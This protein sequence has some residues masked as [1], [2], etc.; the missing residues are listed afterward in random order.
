MGILKQK[1]K[2]YSLNKILEQNAQYNVIIGERSNGKTYACLK[3]ALEQYVSDGGQLGLVRRWA[4]DFKGKRGQQ[5]FDALVQ[6]GEISRI[7]N[8]QWDNVYYYSSR[9][10]FSKFDENEKRVTAPEPF[11]YAFSVGGMEHD[12]STSYPNITTI[13]Y[14]EFLTRGMYLPDEFVLFMNVISTIVRYRTNV[15]IFML[16][17]TVNKYCP[18]FAEMGLNHID[19]MKQGTIDL[20]HYG[21][22]NLRVAVEYCEQA[23]KQGKPS[24]DYFAFNNP[25]LEMITG[26]VWE[27]DIYPHLPIKY[28]PN[29]I[30]FTY[31]IKFNDDIL[32]CEI[33]QH[34]DLLFTFIHRKTTPLKNENDD[35]IY[36][37]EYRPRTNWR[38]N[39]TK[40]ML[41]IEQKIWWFFKNEKI[42]Y[43]DN[44]I[45][46]IV[47][48]YL[49]QCKNIR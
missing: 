25:K 1:P 13:I 49:M 10:Y 21:N 31:F 20:Y 32:Q 48:N 41:P 4:D 16:G 3:Y 46:E 18:Y 33:I 7:T 11:A 17:N 38:R 12:K 5:M 35:L 15:K 40:P 34:D 44:E 36:S 28:I 2:F 22:S 23:N 19:K 29:E 6:N 24:D 27:L 26:G 9:W 37:M 30:L 47:R 8:G 42:F 14:D 45:G 43:Q 39:I